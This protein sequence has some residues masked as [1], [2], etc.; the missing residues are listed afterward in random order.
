MNRLASATSP[1]LL[2]H[3]DN[4]VDWWPWGD[5][6]LAEAR[7]RDVPILLS[8]GY[9]ACHW[10]H[11]MAHES[12]EHPDVAQ[13]MNA[14]F[15]NIKVDREE[16]PDI[17]A[18]YMEATTA[19]T[20]QGG[21]PMTC[22]LT[23]DG[24]PFFAGT[25]FPRTQF[26]A[27]LRSVRQ[28]W[29]EQ[30]DEVIAAGQRVVQALTQV[31][32]VDLA[33]ASAPQ[34]AHLDRAAARLHTQFDA[35]H[36]GF[37]RAPKFPPSMVLE[38]LLRHYERTGDAQSLAIAERTL[39]A[40]ARGG[41]YDQL[42]GGFA[43]YSVDEAWVVPHFE[44]MLYD[45]AL[46]LRVY[47]HWQR[48]RPNP[49]AARIVR[50]TAEFIVR[51]LGTAAGG[52][53]SALDADTDGVEGLT[54]V[55]TPAQLREVLGADGELAAQ[56]FAVSADG[57]FE[58]G[59]STLQL[60]AEG[61]DAQRFAAIRARLLA[62][63]ATRPQPG[64]DDKVVTAWNGLAIAGL[65]EAA[66]TLGERSYLDAATR[67]AQLLV[68]VHVVDGRL[69]RTSRDGAAGDA[70]AVAEDYGDLADGLLLLHQASADPRWLAEAGALL[71]FALTA[72][73]DT[74]GGFFDTAADAERLVRRP[75]DPTD[76]ATPSGASAL[77]AALISYT[78][79]SGATAHREA[80]VSALRI[81]S[82]LGTEQPRFLG[83]ALA[84]AEALVSG[85]VQVAVVGETV[86]QPN[87][88][89]LFDVAWSRRPPGAVV[90]AGAPDAVGV[91]LL[92]DRPLVDG[93]P[94]AYVCRG[95]VCDVPVTTTADLAG[96]LR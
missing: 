93:R 71:D 25:Y 3:K 90:V 70:L 15:V 41:I 68:D 86:G 38:F 62:A 8:V 84:A 54:Y 2:Q 36:G 66:V 4:P 74:G 17:D 92:A 42:A 65:V 40:M 96:K 73:A 64:R 59:A 53:A 88:T 27:L 56:L 58:H 39:T 44:K 89:A 10:C 63:R 80:A 61:A 55:W 50:E 69:R 14:G 6:A 33:D 21:W 75:Q 11:V 12:F 72:F 85:P 18:V 83:W 13:E 7:R 49:M 37:G 24:Q 22:L 82:T 47:A 34:A 60:P 30:R 76:N 48:L 5:E 35:R 87:G 29:A 31:R 79:L 32:G 23:P 52:F 16:R 45:N 19:L 26:L 91:P 57:T 67:C 94:A 1:Y 81:V 28:A 20:G 9:A 46:L 43:R 77:A 95:M 51:D 78:A